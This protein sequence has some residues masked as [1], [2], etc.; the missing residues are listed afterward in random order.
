MD[1]LNS[2]QTQLPH[3]HFPRGFGYTESRVCSYSSLYVREA[4]WAQ[5]L[6]K[7]LCLS[8]SCVFARTV[9]S[10]FGWSVDCGMPCL[11]NQNSSWCMHWFIVGW[12]TVILF[13]CVCL[14]SLV[15]QLQSE[16]NYAVLLICGL[17]L[18]DHITPA[19]MDLHWLPYPQ[20]ITY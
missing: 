15:Q 18:F 19:L 12:I 5:I 16:L 2:N 1:I 3:N 4:L 20:R 13:L 9:I 11:L 8:M 14:K 6:M 7:E 17:K 10:N